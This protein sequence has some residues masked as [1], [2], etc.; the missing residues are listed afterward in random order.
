MNSANHHKVISLA[1]TI[2]VMGEILHTLWCMHTNGWTD[3]ERLEMRACRLDELEPAAYDVEFNYGFRPLRSAVTIDQLGHAAALQLKVQ[4]NDVVE[5]Q[6][7]EGLCVVPHALP[8]SGTQYLA[9]MDFDLPVVFT[10]GSTDKLAFPI[11]AW[12]T[13]HQARGDA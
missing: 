4:V 11:W 5:T 12:P 13:L 3:T 10:D 8:I 7:V 2:E 1:D 6:T 9:S